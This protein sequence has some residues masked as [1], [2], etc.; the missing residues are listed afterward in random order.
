MGKK[1]SQE[2]SE[3]EVQEEDNIQTYPA[4]HYKHQTQFNI[5]KMQDLTGKSL[6]L[7][8]ISNKL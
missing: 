7:P 8:I 3:V 1:D 4:K 5:L 6:G 2:S